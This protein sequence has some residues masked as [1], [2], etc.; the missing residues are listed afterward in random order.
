MEGTGK[1]RKSAL[2]MTQNLMK[3]LERFLLTLLCL[4]SDPWS[5][6]ENSGKVKKTR[7]LKK[8]FSFDCCVKL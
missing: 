2:V 1:G 6:K 4:R 5:L 3:I 7:G 8:N